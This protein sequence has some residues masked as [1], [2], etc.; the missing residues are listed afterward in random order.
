V[1]HF[2]IGTYDVVLHDGSLEIYHGERFVGGF[3]PS[4]TEALLEAL[5]L[6]KESIHRA[7]HRER[8]RF[9]Q[10]EGEKHDAEGYLDQR[11]VELRAKIW[12]GIQKD[13]FFTMAIAGEGKGKPPFAYTIGLDPEVLILG[14]HLDDVQEIFRR[15]AT[16]QKQGMVFTSGK[17]YTDTGILDRLPFYVHQIDRAHYKQYALAAIRWH[18]GRDFSLLQV[19]WPDRSGRLPWQLGYD[20]SLRGDQPL[21]FQTPEME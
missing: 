7:A 8:D 1:E 11:A 14:V 12:T 19:V 4:G 5:Q 13:G 3:L 20:E 15:I 21:L 2:H 6:H 16:R 10:A 9:T 18:H 17:L